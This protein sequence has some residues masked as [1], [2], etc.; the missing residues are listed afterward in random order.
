[1]VM[2]QRPAE[3][4]RSALLWGLAT[5]AVLQVGLAVAIEGWLPELRDPSYAYKARR[6]RRRTGDTHRP[7]A[8]V[9]LGSSRVEHGL[10]GQLLEEQLQA[11]TGTRPVVFNFGVSGAGPVIELLV[12]RRL[13]A[14]GI[15]PDLLLVEVLPPFLA[16][17][18]HSP[19]V[20]RL[21]VDRL[22]LRELPLASRYGRPLAELRAGWWQSWPVPWYSHRFAILTRFA[23]LF[24]PG[25]SPA[26]TF[27]LDDESGWAAPAVSTVTPESY[28]RG[29]AAAQAEYAPYFIGFRLGGTSC[30]ALR[31]LLDLCRQ[32]QIAAALVLMPEGKDFRDLYP[33]LAWA[34]I[35]T[36]LNGLS[37]EYGV[38]LVNAREW[39]CGEHYSD[40]HHL[41]PA[42]AALFTERLGRECI[43][44]LLAGAGTGRQTVCTS[45]AENR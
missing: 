11:E 40:S 15:R 44:P 7:P 13:L 16:G 24:L 9:M 3:Q 12:L 33:P 18:V 25:R 21:T 2:R 17:Q 1:M 6:L 23:P 19:E 38:P 8:V 22:W 14:E 37:W 34:E 36:F 39:V 30:R 28:R 5:F 26:W 45:R 10:R 27:D 35:E 29:L 32:E 43:A 31:E 4:G 20:D 42:G 41:L